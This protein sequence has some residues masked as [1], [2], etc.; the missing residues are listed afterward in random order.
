MSKLNLTIE[1]FKEG[2]T[3]ISHNPELGVSSC[4][5]NPAQAKKNL[6]DAILGF[7][8]SAKELGTLEEILE[9]SGFSF[10]N[11]HWQAPEKISVGKILIAA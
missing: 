11:K 7:I 10:K 8:E 9:E 4:G 6:G 3:Y 1:L 5:K 2:K